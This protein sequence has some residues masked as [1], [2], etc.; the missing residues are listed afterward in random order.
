[1]DNQNHF[2]AQSKIIYDSFFRLPQS[3]K[4]LSVSKGIDRANI[5]R[6]CKT[7]RASKNLA[8]AKRGR[9]SITKRVVNK[10]TTNPTWFPINSQLTFNF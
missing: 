2:Q 10:Y 5:C 8:V 6:Y 7:L 1:M 3:M 4:E 9:C